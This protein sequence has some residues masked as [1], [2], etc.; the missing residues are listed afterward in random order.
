MTL[1][2]VF[3]YV[4]T[5]EPR[6]TKKT[7]RRR[8]SRLNYLNGNPRSVETFRTFFV[9]L[10]SVALVVRPVRRPT[11]IFHVDTSPAARRIDPVARFARA[12]RLA[13]S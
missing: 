7:E 3:M 2:I 5:A 6:K 4:T 9:Q 1:A 8:A 10:V 13:R 12:V 11:R